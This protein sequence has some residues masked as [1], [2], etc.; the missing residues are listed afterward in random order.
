MAADEKVGAVQQY[1]ADQFGA[2]GVAVEAKP[3]GIVFRVGSGASQFNVT[4]VRDF[5]D[6]HDAGRI[7][8]L[9]EGWDLGEELRRADG[10]P[11][12]VSEEGVR[13]ASSN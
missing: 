8:E 9:L 1:L 13:L 12:V 4:V 11:L 3:V 5:L 2:D 10:L 7:R 6:A